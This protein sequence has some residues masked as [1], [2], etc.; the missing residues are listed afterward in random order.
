MA[1]VAHISKKHFGLVLNMIAHRS[2]LLIVDH[3]ELLLSVAQCVVLR[4]H[5]G[6][7]TNGLYQL[8]QALEA[9]LPI[10]KGLLLPSNI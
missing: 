9:L 1:L 2:G 3:C 4:D 5:V 8:K 10:L 7:G 6:T